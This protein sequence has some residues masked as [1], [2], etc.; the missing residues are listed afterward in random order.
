MDRCVQNRD[1]VIRC[2][3]INEVKSGHIYL[4]NEETE[5]SSAK[6]FFYESYNC[7]VSNLKIY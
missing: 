5:S 7:S 1:F 4:I 6:M 3:N 2:F